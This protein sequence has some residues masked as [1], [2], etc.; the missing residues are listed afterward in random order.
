MQLPFSTED[1]LDIFKE[2]NLA[3]FPLQ[4]IFYAAGF[5]CVYFLFKDNIN[6]SRTINTVLAFFWLWMGLAYHIIFFSSINKVA[7]AFG[8][9]FIVQGI[10]FIY[11]GSVKKRIS[12]RYQKSIFNF[13]GIIIIAYSLIFYPIIGH[14]CGHQFPYS[15]TFGLPCPTTIY[16]FGMLLFVNKKIPLPVIIIPFLWSIIGFS[17]AFSLS[18]Y[19]DIGLLVSGILGLVLIILLN[20]KLVTF[21]K[22]LN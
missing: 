7:Y 8:I 15:P 14:I 20:N 16:T 5:I 6:V 2:Y 19:E 22:T 21:I 3:F 12:F 10:L 11:Y 9:L 4:I 13:I 18:I 17:A 1:F